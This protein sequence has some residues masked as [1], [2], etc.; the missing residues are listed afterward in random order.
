MLITGGVK[1]SAAAVASAVETVPGVDA[2]L[3]AG[4]EDPEWGTRVGAAVVGSADDEL[5]RRTV[6][7]ALGP[8][9]V[10]ELAKP[11]PMAGAF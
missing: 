10:S 8:A 6:R 7:E 4:V 11:F 5:I 3:V 2:A 9:A 1:I